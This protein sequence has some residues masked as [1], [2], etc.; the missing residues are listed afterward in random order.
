MAEETNEPTQDEPQEGVNEEIADPRMEAINSIVQGIKARSLQ[1]AQEMPQAGKEEGEDNEEVDT[2]EK[3]EDTEDEPAL[4]GTSAQKAQETP[5]DIASA[6]AKLEEAARLLNQART[7]TAPPVLDAGLSESDLVEVVE[8]I[9]VG[10]PQEG[11]KALLGILNKSKNP[12]VSPEQIAWLVQDRIDLREANAQ[13]AKLYPEIVSDPE[14]TAMALQK[15]QKLLEA[16]DQSLYSDRFN[17]IGT[18]INGWLKK[19]GALMNVESLEAKRKKK[20]NIEHISGKS[21]KRVETPMQKKP[22][23]PQEIIEDMAKMRGQRI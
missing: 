11:A 5:P 20:A 18:E 15:N 22:K 21:N 2:Q 1:E 13:F 19:K 8:Q 10:T 4:D 3:V 17:K 6:T 9:Q 14:L 16:G 23:T 7:A 12:Q